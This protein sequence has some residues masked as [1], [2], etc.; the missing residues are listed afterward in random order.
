MQRQTRIERDGGNSIE[1]GGREGE[2]I[3]VNIEKGE[4]REDMCCNLSCNF[5]IFFSCFYI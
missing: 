2:G 1:K 5:F 3:N 4:K